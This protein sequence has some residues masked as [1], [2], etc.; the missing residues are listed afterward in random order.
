MRVKLGIRH[1]AQ[2]MIERESEIVCALIAELRAPL[3][4]VLDTQLLLACRCACL[5]QIGGRNIN[6]RNFVP[7]SCKLDS[8]SSIAT[9]DIENTR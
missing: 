9:S 5:I 8:M 4:S 6:P 2:G 1:E 3:E 7:A